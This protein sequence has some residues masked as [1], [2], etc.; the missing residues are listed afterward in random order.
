MLKGILFIRKISL[1]CDV[2]YGALCFLYLFETVVRSKG[3]RSKR[4]NP[5]QCQIVSL[6]TDAS[7]QNKHNRNNGRVYE[8]NTKSLAKYICI[9]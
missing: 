8:R 9:F 4:F 5:Q 2:L 3:Y 7:I 6:I 1:H